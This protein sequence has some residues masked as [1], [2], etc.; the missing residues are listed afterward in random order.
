[1]D[2]PA[3]TRSLI[4]FHQERF[5]ITSIV[6]PLHRGVSEAPQL[7]RQVNTLVVHKKLFLW[8]VLNKCK[9]FKTLKNINLITLSRWDVIFQFLDAELALLVVLPS[10][11]HSLGLSVTVS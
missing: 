4:S 10:L 3:A 11:P 8:F 2:L 1:M 9:T 7:I 6:A 5:L